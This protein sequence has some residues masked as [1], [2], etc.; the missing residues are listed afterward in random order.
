VAVGQSEVDRWRRLRVAAL[1]VGIV[2]LVS[3]VLRDRDS[4]PLSTYPVYSSVRP[5]VATFATAHGERAD[6]SMRRL[7]MDVIARTDDPLIAASRLSDAVGAGRADEACAAIAARAPDDV[8]AVVVVRER[9][10]VVAAARGDDSVLESEE[11]ARCAVP[12]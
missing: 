12:S 1:V 8:V 11:L 3:P 5:A 2:V 10:N 6:G 7:S 9:H 4:F